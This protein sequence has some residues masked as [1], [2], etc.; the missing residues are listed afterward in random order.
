MIRKRKNKHKKRMIHTIHINPF[1]F[2]FQCQSW[3]SC[4]AY[5]YSWVID[6]MI[7]RCDSN[8][9]I[10]P[11]MARIK[12]KMHLVKHSFFDFLFFFFE[13]YNDSKREN[14]VQ[15]PG[16]NDIFFSFEKRALFPYSWIWGFENVI[17]L[18]RI[19]QRYTHECAKKK[20]KKKYMVYK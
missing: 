17:V 13:F 14:I 16:F 20:K 9:H 2:R 11:V 7:K 18:V 5:K 3:T 8:I 6:W 15:Y 1:F 4:F 19:L 12:K 10:V